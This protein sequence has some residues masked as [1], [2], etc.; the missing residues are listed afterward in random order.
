MS[1]EPPRASQPAPE[2]ATRLLFAFVL[3]SL[4]AL[5]VI[6]WYTDYR[7]QP[8][9]HRL[10]QMSDTGRSLM[11]Q[12]HLNMSLEGSAFDEYVN[13]RDTAALGPRVDVGEGAHPDRRSPDHAGR[14]RR[15]AT[16]ALRLQRQV[17]SH[18]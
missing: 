11:I 12:V 7:L 5:I 1:D 8:E 6:P 17:G 14:A 3:L 15:A 4:A 10:N 2:W 18:P 13:T 16:E 9:E